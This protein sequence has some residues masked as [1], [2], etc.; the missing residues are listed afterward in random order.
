MRLYRSFRTSV[1]YLCHFGGYDS[2]SF[3]YSFSF[4]PPSFRFQGVYSR[5]R[6]K[7]FR[8]RV[9]GNQTTVLNEVRGLIVGERKG[10]MSNYPRDAHGLEK[11]IEKTHLMENL[12]R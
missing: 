11:T 6:A 8:A 9:N 5:N 10:V 7:T 3:F 4:S 12:A 2:I 1:P